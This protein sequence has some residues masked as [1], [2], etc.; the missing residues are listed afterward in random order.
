MDLSGWFYGKLNKNI[1]LL[2]ILNL[3]AETW[4]GHDC[5]ELVPPVFFVF[6]VPFVDYR[7]VKPYIIL[8][9]DEGGQNIETV[10]YLIQD[11]FV[12]FAV[13]LFGIIFF[14]Y[15]IHPYFDFVVDIGQ[16][17]QKSID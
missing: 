16:D 15:E 7:L 17:A 9:L 6:V 8:L 13:K 1:N 11:E 14:L 12:R 4:H 5:H 10:Q 2:N 3:L